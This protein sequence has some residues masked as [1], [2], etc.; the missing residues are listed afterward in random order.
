[1][2]RRKVSHYEVSLRN[3]CFL[4]DIYGAKGRRDAIRQARSVSDSYASGIPEK[5]L[6]AELIFETD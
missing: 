3:G 1:M 4:C 5:E 6:I 2:L